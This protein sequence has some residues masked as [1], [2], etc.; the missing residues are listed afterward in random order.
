MGDVAPG[1]RLRASARSWIAAHRSAGGDCSR[2][3]LALVKPGLPATAFGGKGL[4]RISAPAPVPP[5]VR[6]Q[7]G[8]GSPISTHSFLKRGRKYLVRFPALELYAR[9]ARNEEAER[10][11][12]EIRERAERRW[13]SPTTSSTYASRVPMRVKRRQSPVEKSTRLALAGDW[14]G[15]HPIQPKKPY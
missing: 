2:G 8:A 15:G 4:T 6:R 1:K 9:Q 10:R 5:C 12:R 14:V 11:C 13:V 7:G 3:G